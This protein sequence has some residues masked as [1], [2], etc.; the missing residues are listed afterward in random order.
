[1]MTAEQLSTIALLD[2]GCATAREMIAHAPPEFLRSIAVW[3]DKGDLRYAPHEII[4]FIQFFALIGIVH[5]AREA[6]ALS[7]SSEQ[8]GQS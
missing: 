8:G 5:A 7:T 1:M 3:L 2:Q 6:Q 4:R